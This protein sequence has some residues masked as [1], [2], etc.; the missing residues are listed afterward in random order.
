[1]ARD[2]VTPG[3]PQVFQFSTDAF[4]EHERVSAWR[5]AFGR[6]LLN[7]DIA[8]QSSEAFHASA[9]IF[10]FADLGLIRAST[11]AVYQCNSKG[12]ITNDDISF[13]GVLTSRWTAKQL[14][15]SE[16]LFPGDAVLLSN[17][18]VGAL[19]FPDECRYTVFS[20]PKSALTSLVPDIGALFARR[21]PAS[22]PA[23]RMLMRYLELAQEEHPAASPEL[24]MAFSSHVCDL[25]ALCLGAT[26]DATELAR[27]RGVTAARLCAIKDDIRKACSD[28]DLS[29]HAIA[30]RYGVSARYVQRLF[31]ESG[32][33]FTQYVTEQR[34]AAAYEALRRRTLTDLP[35]STVAYDC[36]FADVSHFNRAFRQRFGCTPTDIRNAAR[37]R[38]G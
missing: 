23:L 29:V 35:I 31:E 33:T 17:G 10:R 20:I 5:E 25:L 28:P 21:V 19:T 18:E 37:S 16:D 1:M 8:P 14:G 15:R 12:L 34:L 9:T 22:S 7:I 2:E 4:R 27:T 24:Q 32:A 11:S 30:A 3:H 26:R 36:G 13:G 38:N 6:T